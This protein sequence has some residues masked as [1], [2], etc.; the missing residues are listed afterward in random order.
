ML[1]T[2]T[3]NR[4]WEKERKK[5]KQKIVFP[6]LNS[7]SFCCSFKM[8]SSKFWIKVVTVNFIMQTF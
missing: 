3:E 4:K 6:E 2:T 5:Q 1:K 7:K 8:T